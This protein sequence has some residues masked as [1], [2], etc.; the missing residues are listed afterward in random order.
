MPASPPPEAEPP[1]R[2]RA[3][4]LR[5]PW[6]IAVVLVAVALSAG[7]GSAVTYVATR[8][9][10]AAAPSPPQGSRSTSPPP[11]ESPRVSAADAAAAKQHLCQVFDMS[12]SGQAGQGGARVAGGGVNMPIVLRAVNSALAVQSALSPALPADVAEAAKNYVSTTLDE[13]TTAMGSA[14]T[15]EVNRLTD[16]RNNAINR[17]LDVCGLPK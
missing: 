13:T 10:R 7:V 16:L 6:V 9:D 3:S 1:R 17:L 4:G 5:W 11:S 2:A 14:P 12:T 15:S 8:G